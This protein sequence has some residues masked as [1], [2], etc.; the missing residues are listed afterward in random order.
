MPLNVHLPEHY[1][2]LGNMAVAN[3]L[4]PKRQRKILNGFNGICFEKF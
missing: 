1:T 2:K 3:E 4:R